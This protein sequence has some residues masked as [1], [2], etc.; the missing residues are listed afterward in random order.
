MDSK[1]NITFNINKINTKVYNKISNN[2]AT[3]TSW[4][5]EVNIGDRG[6]TL[7]GNPHNKLFYK[8]YGEYIR[9]DMV[10]E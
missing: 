10:N 5:M 4:R 8:V 7:I 6:V 9:I 1:I 2:P 3:I